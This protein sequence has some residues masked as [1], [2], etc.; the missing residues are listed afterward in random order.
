MTDNDDKK[1][2][3]A[4]LDEQTHTQELNTKP[5]A[6]TTEGSFDGAEKVKGEPNLQSESNSVD[7]ENTNTVQNENDIENN[8]DGEEKGKGSNGEKENLESENNADNVLDKD[9]AKQEKKEQ[10]I[11][12]RAERAEAKKSSKKNKDGN[13][14]ENKE[15]TSEFIQELIGVAVKTVAVFLSL[16]VLITS[17][18]TVA[19]PLNAMRVFNKLGMTERAMNS[20]E[21]YIQSRLVDRNAQ[22]PDEDGWYSVL[23]GT[24]ETTD[25]DFIESLTV[26]I[27][28]ADKLM[29]ENKGTDSEK[30]FAEKLDK[31]IRI[32]M[33]L[34]DSYNISTQKSLENRNS[35]NAALR[36]YVY[37]YTHSLIT[38]DYKAR[39]AMG[40]TDYILWNP[41]GNTNFITTLTER[42][43]TFAGTLITDGTSKN[44]KAQIL[45][46]FV[47]YIGALNTYL[48]EIQRSLGV[49][50]ML[51]ESDTWY[52]GVLTGSE[53][54]VFI[55]PEKGFTT[56][57]GNLVSG[58]SSFTTY[59]KEAVEFP[60]TSTDEELRQLHWLKTLASFADN[61][62][63]LGRL[64]NYSSSV[65]GLYADDIINDYSTFV[66]DYLRIVNKTGSGSVFLSDEYNKLVA[67]YIQHID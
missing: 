1:L 59:A 4:S 3:T 23:A 49:S 27:T 11:N 63:N 18:L 32:Y 36:P 50:G 22:T 21:R 12:L 26:S 65:Y 28:L 8:N 66:F 46:A 13:S 19:L 2:N 9:K 62:T 41:I 20:G 7:N 38:L 56:V 5:D 40:E 24:S 31:F 30:Y 47:D 44:S 45:D 10:I 51:T 42:S 64:L 39:M 53:F 25:D 17:L 60:T 55:T 15:Q 34:P 58:I 54:S 16:V 37:S 14:E 43:Q 52:R 35:V 29:S 67:A 33:S 57:Y 6:T 61:F 48:V